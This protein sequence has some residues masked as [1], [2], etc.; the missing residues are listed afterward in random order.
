MICRECG[1]KIRV[2][3]TYATPTGKTQRLECEGCHM[4]FT[5]VLLIVNQDPDRGEG[6]AALARRICAGEEAPWI[7]S[8][9]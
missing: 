5:G 1:E 2:R 9:S 4:T 6:A 8:A 3:Q 7:P